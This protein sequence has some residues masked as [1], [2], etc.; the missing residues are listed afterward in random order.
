MFN[1]IPIQILKY[2]SEKITEL[3]AT[4]C[5]DTCRCKSYYHT[6]SAIICIHSFFSW[7]FLIGVVCSTIFCSGGHH[8]R[9]SSKVHFTQ[10]CFHSDQWIFKTFSLQSYVQLIYVLW[11]WPYCIPIH[12]LL[13]PTMSQGAGGGHIGFQSIKTS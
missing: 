3:I 10:I 4:D 5:I 11:E 2:Y 12:T 1:I 6:I 7:H 9:G 8:F 13:C